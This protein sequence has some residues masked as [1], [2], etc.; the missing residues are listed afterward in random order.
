MVAT[1]CHVTLKIFDLNGRE[2]ALLID[3]KYEAGYYKVDFNSRDL[4]SGL[5]FYRIRMNQF[6]D[7]KKMIKI[8]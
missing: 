8:E 7:V 5:Y 2:I 6:Q 1:N 3:S 4:S